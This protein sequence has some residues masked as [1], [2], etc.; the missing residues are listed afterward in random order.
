M[1]FSA[2][3]IITVLPVDVFFF[4]KDPAPTEIYPLPQ[5]APLPISPPPPRV[6]RRPRSLVVTIARG[7]SDPARTLLRER[8]SR[9]SIPSLPLGRTSPALR[10]DRRPCTQEIGRAHV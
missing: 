9:V 1:Q 2:T 4:L 7:V 8:A 5:H 10:A 3:H 6:V